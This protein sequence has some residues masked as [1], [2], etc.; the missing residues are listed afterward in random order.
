[1]IIDCYTHVG[2]GEMLEY[3]WA[4]NLP[5]ELVIELEEKAGIDKAVIFPAHYPPELY[6]RANEEVDEA[7][8]RV[9][10]AS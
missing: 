2:K 3:W 8:R 6:G 5:A 7:A 4:V 1:M 9:G 10:V